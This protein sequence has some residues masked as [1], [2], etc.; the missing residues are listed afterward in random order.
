MPLGG[1]ANTWFGDCDGST[2]K[3]EDAKSEAEIR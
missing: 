1:P 3:I 2:L